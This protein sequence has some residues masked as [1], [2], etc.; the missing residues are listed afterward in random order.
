MPDSGNG[1]NIRAAKANFSKLVA[2][3]ETG[4]E[5]TISRRGKPVA[6]LV[7]IKEPTKRQLGLMKDVFSVPVN[8][9]E[10]LAEDAFDSFES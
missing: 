4:E 6:K 8:F 3:V 9:D 10:P 1:I 5:I 2:R 7:P